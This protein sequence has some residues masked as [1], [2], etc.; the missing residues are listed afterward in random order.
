MSLKGELSEFDEDRLVKMLDDE[1]IVIMP[2]RLQNHIPFFCP[3]CVVAMNGVT[4][5]L[6]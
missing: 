2:D 6:S 1:I 5:T 3:I 4:D